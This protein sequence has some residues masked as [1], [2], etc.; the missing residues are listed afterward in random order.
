MA[1]KEER[2]RVEAGPDT[3]D[4][5]EYKEMPSLEGAREAHPHALATGPRNQVRFPA[6]T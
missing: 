5:S 4:N 2:Y 6:S 3:T 1:G